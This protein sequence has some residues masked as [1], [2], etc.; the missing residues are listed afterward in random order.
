MASDPRGHAIDLAT[1]PI[2]VLVAGAG[3]AL[4]LLHHDR[5]VDGMDTLL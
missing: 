4:L 2:H 1:G 5:R 3:R